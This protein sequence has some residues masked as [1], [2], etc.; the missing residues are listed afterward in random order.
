M[1]EK[2]S[3]SNE[4]YTAPFIPTHQ[5]GEA[6]HKGIEMHPLVFSIFKKSKEVA[7][8]EVRLERE[9]ACGGPSGAR[10]VLFLLTSM[11]ILW[12]LPYHNSFICTFNFNVLVH[13]MLYFI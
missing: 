3:D 8:T 7:A 13:I 5:T 9:E 2:K 4:Y 1:A 6:K 12:V 11:L 10:A